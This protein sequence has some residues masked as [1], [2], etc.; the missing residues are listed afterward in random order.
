MRPRSWQ[1]QKRCEI[2]LLG[3]SA[4]KDH[5]VFVM[6]E[7]LGDRNVSMI[8]FS[9]HTSPADYSRLPS[10]LRLLKFLFLSVP[11]LAVP[12]SGGVMTP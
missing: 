6:A 12:Y 1:R 7:G 10:E 9:Q 2:F 11:A 4:G 5:I 3:D 8:V